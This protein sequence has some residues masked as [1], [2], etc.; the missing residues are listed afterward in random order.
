MRCEDRPQGIDLI[1]RS[2][3]PALALHPDACCDFL[4]T[5]VGLT[6][7]KS[8]YHQCALFVR[9]NLGSGAVWLFTV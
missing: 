8:A 2:F 6:G 3:G 7:E 5:L 1:S 4:D 9:R